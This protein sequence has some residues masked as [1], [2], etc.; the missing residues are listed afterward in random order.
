MPRQMSGHDSAAAD[1][2]WAGKSA[3][4]KPPL[5]MPRQQVLTQS[6]QTRTPLRHTHLRHPICTPARRLDWITILEILLVHLASLQ[7]K[8]FSFGLKIPVVSITHQLPCD[9]TRQQLLQAAPHSPRGRRRRN[10]G[11]DCEAS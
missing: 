4:I 3:P 11:R 2:E 1:D 7:Q 8:A 6:H 5:L 10:T 9:K